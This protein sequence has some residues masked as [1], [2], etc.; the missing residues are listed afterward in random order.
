MNSL[1]IDTSSSNLSLALKKDEKV[2]SS[3]LGDP[4][5]IAEEVNYLIEELAKEASIE[6]KD[7]NRIYVTVG[8]G[9][10]TGERI[11]L[12][13]AKTFYVLNNSIEIYVASTLKVMSYGLK[14]C[15][16]LLDAKNK[17]YF[18]SHYKEG[19]KLTEEVIFEHEE[20]INSIKKDIPIAILTTQASLK[21]RFEGY[22]IKEVDLLNNLI[23]SES[24]FELST[25][26]LSIKASYL[27]GKNERN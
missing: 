25:S 4:K 19:E 7:L 5:K 11:G 2:F 6:L 26:P 12:T 24:Y 22:E 21:E 20:L 1:F 13:I 23:S 8:P 10:Y 9:S 14:E 16:V 15:Y 27:R 17:A 18:F 3:N